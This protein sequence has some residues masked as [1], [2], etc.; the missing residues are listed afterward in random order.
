MPDLI[1]AATSQ[2]IPGVRR[3]VARDLAKLATVF[4]ACVALTLALGVFTR[5]LAAPLETLLQCFALLPLLGV[6]AA[7]RGTRVAAAAAAAAVLLV[8][9]S[10]GSMLSRLPNPSWVVQFPV[11]GKLTQIAI[12]FLVVAWIGSSQWHRYGLRL[13]Q[14][15]GTGRRATMLA[16]ALPITLFAGVLVLLVLG[17]VDKTT[18]IGLSYRA[19]FWEGLF[20][21]FVLVG[22]AE[23]LWFRGMLQSYLDQLLPGHVRVWGA[24]LGWGFVLTALMFVLVHVIEARTGP[25]RI[26]T[27]TSSAIMVFPFAVIAGYLRSYTGSLLLPIVLHGLFDGLGDVVLPAL[28]VRLF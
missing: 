8:W 6:V 13:S 22:I 2:T 21:Q 23:E 28:A 7:H 3:T 15:A 4:A 9:C 20:F 26:L 18:I 10:T 1:A 19:P 16:V 25:V 27:D 14:D 12:C 11:S 24:N 5:A 17:V